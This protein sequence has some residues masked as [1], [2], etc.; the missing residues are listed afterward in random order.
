MSGELDPITGPAPATLT[1]ALLAERL[2]SERA[3][4]EQAMAYI[5]KAL[6][7]Q[8]EEYERR[9]ESLNGEATRLAKVLDQSVPREV[10]TNYVEAQDAK[11]A[12]ASSVAESART[13]LASQVT[14]ERNARIRLEGALGTW[15]AI[16]GFL[17]LSGIVGVLLGLIA[18]FGPVQ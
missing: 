6:Q 2:A 12:L 16:A 14:I 13:E 18:V 15:R 1:T 7:L 9:L 5:D 11:L 17:G 4:R 3:L 10:F 8:A